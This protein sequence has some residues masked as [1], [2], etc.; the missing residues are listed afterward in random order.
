[1]SGASTTRLLDNDERS[2][3]DELLSV[4]ESGAH[5]INLGQ[6]EHM[7][8]EDPNDSGVDS[9]DEHDHQVRAFPVVPRSS[10]NFPL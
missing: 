10:V 1:M 3:K 5:S 2:E 8:E 4:H 9:G 6:K 7:L